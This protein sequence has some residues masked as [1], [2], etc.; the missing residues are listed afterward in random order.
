MK[1]L[2]TILPIAILAVVLSSCAV[3]MPMIITDNTSGGKVG[4][5]EYSTTIFGI[6]PLNRDASIA[7]AAKNGGITKITSV[8]YVVT[9]KLFKT[10]YKTIVTGE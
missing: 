7:T 8:D 3:S 10:T 5:A 1:V 4:T 9:G 6:G 2:K